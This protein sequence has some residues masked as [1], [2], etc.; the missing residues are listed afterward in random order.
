MSGRSDSCA[1]IRLNDGEEC[2]E[3]SNLS[4]PKNQ[5]ES[6]AASPGEEFRPMQRQIEQSGCVAVDRFKSKDW[7]ART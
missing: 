5:A 3:G 1:G 7:I 2:A 6:S 4:A